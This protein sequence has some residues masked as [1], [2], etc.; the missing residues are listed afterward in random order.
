MLYELAYTLAGLVALAYAADFA[1]GLRD[2][3]RE[4]RRVRPRIPF[5]GHV[6]GIVRYGSAYYSQTRQRETENEIYALDVV[7]LK[8]YVEQK[9]SKTLSFR[10]FTNVAAR[11]MA[12]N[13]EPACDLFNGPLV[14]E[15]SQVVKIAL[16]PGSHQDNQNLR[17]ANSVISLVDGISNEGKEKPM[18]LLESTKHVIVEAN[19]C[20]EV[21]KALWSVFI[22][23]VL[24][25]SIRTWGWQAHLHSH[26]AGLD[27][28]GKANKERKV[29]HKAF[30]KWCRELRD[31]TSKVLLD[32]QRIVKAA[33]MDFEDAA[34]QE[35]LFCVAIFSN[36]APTLY[37]TIWELFSRPALLEEVRDELEEH[38]ITRDEGDKDGEG[39]AQHTLDIT[40]LKT[41]CAI[42]LS[43]FIDNGRYLLRKGNYV[44]MPGAPIHYDESVWGPTAKT[45]D[46]EAKQPGSKPFAPL[47]AGFLAWGTP[48]H[49]CP[50][51]QFATTEILITV[52]LLAVQYHLVP[53]AS[54]SE[55]EKNPAID[56]NDVVAV[57]NPL[58]DVEVEAK[59][60]KGAGNWTVKM[61]KSKTQVVI[62]SG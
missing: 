14:D 11:D 41:Q 30:F 16:L 8:L 20:A 1:F 5:I 62:A 34:K 4:P 17:M 50:A 2:D 38:A 10:P 58:K 60:R 42:L 51:R 40:A 39:T 55:W 57:F 52:A 53:V 3:P 45:F 59:P 26:M 56:Y 27:F 23:L 18:G 13:S 35:T 28:F 32:R 12:G 46:P 44:Q 21:E 24:I 49:L 43:M 48:L 7:A 25:V 37:W 15:Y 19:S 29:V 36:T 61:G 6:L 33:G 47:P 54:N 31:D 9:A 22:A